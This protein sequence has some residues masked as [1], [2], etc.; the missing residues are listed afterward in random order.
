M[1]SNSEPTAEQGEIVLVEAWYD[2]GHYYPGGKVKLLEFIPDINK[3][4]PAD[5]W[6]VD[7]TSLSKYDFENVKGLPYLNEL[8]LKAYSSRDIIGVS[9]KK[10]SKPK[11]NFSSNVR[12]LKLIFSGC[13]ACQ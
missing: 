3:W 10:T 8:L 1:Y 12:L 6:I 2:G 9:L 7:E 5:I 4:N 11:L 13:S